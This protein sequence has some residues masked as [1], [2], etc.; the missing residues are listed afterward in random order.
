MSSSSYCRRWIRELR[1][2]MPIEPAASKSGAATRERIPE[3]KMLWALSK[4]S[5][6]STSSTLAEFPWIAT[7]S[8]RVV[9]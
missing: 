4:R 8:M 3:L 5:S 1:A 9:E 7:S 6:F 2:I